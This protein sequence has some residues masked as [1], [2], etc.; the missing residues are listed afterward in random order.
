M[1]HKFDPYRYPH[2]YP[3]YPPDHPVIQAIFLRPIFASP[4]R[5][6]KDLRSWPP[7]EILEGMYIRKGSQDTR[8][9]I[10]HLIPVD[11]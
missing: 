11:M 4:E 1:H 5:N 7:L 8:A 9:K 6:L 2:R 10:F 3:L